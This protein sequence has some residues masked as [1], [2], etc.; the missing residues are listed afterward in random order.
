VD[1]PL[2]ANATPE[3]VA[4]MLRHSRARIL[5]ASDE[6]QVDKVLPSLP[7]LPDLKEVVVVSRA[8]ADR[9]GLLSLEQ[10]VAQG[11]GAFDDAERAARAARVKSRDVA[12]VMYTSGTTGRPKGIAFD[13]LN[14]V[15]K[16]LCRGFALPHV[17]ERDV[18]L[19]YLPLYHTFGRYLEMTGSL[20]WGAT[21]VFARS[22]GQA[23]LAEDFKN[24]QPTVFIS[25]P[26]KWMELQETAQRQAPPDDPEA[27]A[28]QLRALTGGRLA[29]GLSAA[30]YLD[31]SVFRAFHKA[32]VELCSGYGMT[33][34]AR[35][36]SLSRASSASAPRTGSSSS[37]AP[38]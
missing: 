5:V 8:A 32:G 6:E 17:N 31:P 33:W 3:Q 38:T 34:T 9:H 13:H 7:G 1:F 11:A 15:S 28:G 23:A 24:V 10:A 36:A 20:W 37:A 14:I 35:S 22:T 4:Y 19:A 30:G 2:P 12:T 25:V 26:K 29:H 16:R 18:F 27:A 21:Y